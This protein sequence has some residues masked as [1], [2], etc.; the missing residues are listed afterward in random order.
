MSDVSD[1]MPLSSVAQLPGAFTTAC[2]GTHAY[3]K[4]ARG[5]TMTKH[6]FGANK[7]RQLFAIVLEPYQIYTASKQVSTIDDVKGLKLRSTG[8]AMEIF[9]RNSGAIPDRMATQEAR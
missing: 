3:W 4:I 7:V 9:T 6:E 5:E 8:G 1:K 2:E